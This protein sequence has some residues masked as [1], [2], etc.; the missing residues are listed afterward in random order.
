MMAEDEGDDRSSWVWV[1]RVLLPH[2]L[3]CA[4][5]LSCIR[6]WHTHEGWVPGIT[7]ETSVQYEVLVPPGLVL[8]SHD[9]TTHA[10]LARGVRVYVTV[11]ADG[12][13]DRQ[14]LPTHAMY[15]PPLG[16]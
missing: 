11:R 5:D 15:T 9:A 2:G 6:W 4:A 3:D 8:S 12:S 14:E 1:A 16:D 10:D 13:L 7:S